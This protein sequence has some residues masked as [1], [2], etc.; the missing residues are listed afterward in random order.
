MQVNDKIE[1]IRNLVALAN[2]AEVLS[3]LNLFNKEVIKR[4]N[5][6]T[7]AIGYGV[8][9]PH[10]ISR[11]AKKLFLALARTALPLNFQAADGE[12]GRFVILS[13]APPQH[14]YEHM[15]LLAKLS[16]ILSLRYI[17]TEL[18]NAID[19]DSVIQV[20]KAREELEN[21]L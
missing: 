12:P 13:G 21:G 1:A 18:I 8:A 5:D 9:L 20:F 16:R 14:P 3:D 17:R 7:T 2:E 19:A 11:A 10:S 6:A 15:Q 4:E